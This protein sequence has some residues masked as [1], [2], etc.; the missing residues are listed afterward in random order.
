ME[1]GGEK[2]GDADVAAGAEDRR[3]T[4]GADEARSSLDARKRRG[5]ATGQLQ[6]AAS[7]QRRRRNGPERQATLTADDT[8]LHAAHTPD[9]HDRPRRVSVADS[10]GYRQRGVN[11][12][13]RAPARQPDG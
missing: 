8:L 11:V 7:A 1:P 9:I 2:Q 6:R 3:R 5:E 13:A 10:G 12:A 4:Q